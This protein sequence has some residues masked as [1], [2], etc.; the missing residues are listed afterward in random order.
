MP[1]V[2]VRRR[3]D[4]R[5]VL[6]VGVNGGKTEVLHVVGPTGFIKEDVPVGPPHSAAVE[7]IDHRVAVAFSVRPAFVMHRIKPLLAPF[8][9]QELL[10]GVGLFD[11]LEILVL[12]VAAG[13]GF[14]PMEA[15]APGVL[16]CVGVVE[17]GVGAVRDE[18]AVVV[19]N[20]DLLVP[21]S[22]SFHGR[23]E[24]VFQEITLLL[25]G[26]DARFPA[27]RRH[28][29]V[30]DGNPPY[31]EPF[32]L[33]SLDEFDEVVGPR[34]VVFGQQGAAPQHVVVGFHEGWRAPRARVK[35]QAISNH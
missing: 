5:I 1:D 14:V 25:S 9:E 34:L 20:D 16:R 6:G 10:V 7:V 21:V 8:R 26:V 33:V 29:F 17:N 30:L 27:L 32:R 31:W 22:G 12:R 11:E 4:E 18:I 28:G 19:P 2:V 13:P 23:T 3:E 24:V 15:G 35:D